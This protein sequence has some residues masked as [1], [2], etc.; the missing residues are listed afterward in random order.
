MLLDKLEALIE[1]AE[2]WR[3]LERQIHDTEATKAL[4]YEVARLDERIAWV[5]AAGTEL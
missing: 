3:R 4:R 1:R 2:R 5:V